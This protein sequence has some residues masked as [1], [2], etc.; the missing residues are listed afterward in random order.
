MEERG[1]MDPREFRR[2]GR[3]VVDWIA[4]YLAGVD[5][6]PVLARVRPGEIA[7]A[8]P[9][10]PPAEPIPLDETL[11]D[12][13]EILLPGI[14]HWNH[15]RFHAYFAITG[16]APGVLAEALAAALNVN[17]MLWRTSPAATELETVVLGWLRRMMG[18]PASF[19]GHINDTA[20]VSTLVALAAAR[21]VA[22]EGTV[23][24]RGL[25]GGPRLRLYTSEEAHSSVEKAALLL[26]LGREGVRRIPTDDAF[27]MD[28]SALERTVAEDRAAGWTPM[29]V[30]ATV[31]TTSTT[32]VDPV[33]AIADLCEREKI[34]LH[35]D[36]AYGGAM[37]LVPEYR[38]VLDGC[39][40][41]DSLVVNPH[42]WL[43]VPID[44]S[45]LY[46]R[47]PEVIRE[48]FS[49]VPPYLMTPEDGLAR[50]LMDYGPSLGRRFRALKLWMVIRTFGVRGMAERIRAHVEMARSF[51]SWVD[52]APDWERMAPAPMSTVL[53]R[54]RP[55]GRPSEDALDEHNRRLL[56]A[57]NATGRVFLSHTLVRGRF[58]LRLA[59]GNLKTTLTHMRE[60]WSLLRREAEAL[61]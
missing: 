18:L 35:V 49:L 12:F 50:N 7:S 42:K 8:L 16:S 28:V 37:A 29:A 4:D 55:A 40:R 47:R 9:S 48:A 43:F 25:A 22:T 27:R 38:W 60:T 5:D 2:Y 54:H 24:E 45:A 56:E 15:P 13:H 61:D 41:A 52:E 57:V 31:G 1:D 44:L 10:E 19:D 26:G 36:A 23:R 58:A 3:E 59:I 53:F 34:W 11:R 21:Q 20:S 17:A 33:P 46:C 39:E 30:S 6:Y 14:T 32:S 51:A